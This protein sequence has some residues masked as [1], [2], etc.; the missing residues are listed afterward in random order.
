[1]VTVTQARAPR[2]C[3]TQLKG[4]TSQL[5][6]LDIFAVYYCALGTENWWYFALHRIKRLR[7]I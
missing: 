2:T 1:M 6:L 7:N 5:Y 3:G 4:K